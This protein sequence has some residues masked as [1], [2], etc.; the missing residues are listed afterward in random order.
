[1]L[2]CPYTSAD[3]PVETA[4]LHSE[5]IQY[6]VETTYFWEIQMLSWMDKGDS[7]LKGIPSRASTGRCPKGTTD[8]NTHTVFPTHLTQQT[9]KYLF[10][11]YFFKVKLQWMK[12]ALAYLPN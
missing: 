4:S 11:F 6:K 5:V 10:I 2:Q 12:S 3:L 9:M 7:S 8:E 1:M